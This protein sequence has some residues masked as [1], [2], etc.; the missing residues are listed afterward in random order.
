MYRQRCSRA[1]CQEPAFP[2]IDLRVDAFGRLRYKHHGMARIA[3]L[4]PS[5][6]QS[7]RSILLDHVSG[8][9]THDDEDHPCASYPPTIPLLDSHACAHDWRRTP[10][11]PSLLHDPGY[12]LWAGICKLR[13]VVPPLLL[14]L[15]RGRVWTMGSLGHLKHLQ[16]PRHQLPDDP[17]TDSREERKVKWCCQRRAPRERPHRLGLHTRT[18]N[19]ILIL[20]QV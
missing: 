7:P 14:R 13:T 4:P 18:W 2:A 10:G 1:T 20:T 8:V 15:R 19:P 3:I 11:Q 9:R 17:E 16:L 6:G 12:G 5:G